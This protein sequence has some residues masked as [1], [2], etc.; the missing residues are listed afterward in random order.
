MQ[1][2]MSAASAGTVA[3]LVTAPLDGIKT[4][5]QVTDSPQR[6]DFDPQVIAKDIVNRS[7]WSGLVAGAWP[8]IAT[9][10]PQQFIMFGARRIIADLLKQSDE[11]V[12]HGVA[13]YAGSAAHA[14]VDNLS[15]VTA[16]PR[17]EISGLVAHT[18]ARVISVWLLYPFFLLKTR[19]VVHATLGLEN[20]N[21]TIGQ[22]IQNEGAMSLCR[23][24]VPTLA[25]E[26]VFEVS[27]FLFGKVLRSFIRDEFTTGLL[28]ATL[29][30]VVSHPLNT[31][32]T[33][34]Q[35]Q[36]ENDTY[37]AGTAAPRTS[38]DTAIGA[39]KPVFET[40]TSTRAAETGAELTTTT[41][42][43]QRGPRRL[44]DKSCNWDNLFRGALPAAASVV[45]FGLVA[46]GVYTVAKQFFSDADNS[47]T[48][49][50]LP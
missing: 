11:Q 44:I 20:T 10:L 36:Q 3:R 43:V 24:V 9:M 8:S 23:G 34:L 25:S 35:A 28:A 17:H 46:K 33:R 32:A 40:T 27:C 47:S 48:V 42:T 45:I 31:I 14:T 19:S 7:G 16:M 12:R 41:T 22:V 29:A 18:A 30:T 4:V 26:V 37:S 50:S 15:D 2:V 38:R 21:T 1:I 13:G 6:D 49:F 39:A 5:Q